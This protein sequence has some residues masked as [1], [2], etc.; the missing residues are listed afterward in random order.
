[1][2]LYRVL[3]PLVFMQDPEKTHARTIQLLKLLRIGHLGTCPPSLAVKIAGIEFPSAIGLAAGFDKNGEV[4]DPLFRLGFGFV[5]VGTVT[6]RPQA[7][8]P[9]KRLFRVEDE[10]AVVNRFGFN[11]QGHDALERRLRRRRPAGVLGIN[12]GANRDSNDKI[13]DFVAGVE[14][15]SP[16]ASY[17]S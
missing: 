12:I 10:E 16:F 11:N 8:N 17:L 1:M 2:S 4:I 5:E 9:G 7:G 6:P 14:R 13:A 15:F 3:R